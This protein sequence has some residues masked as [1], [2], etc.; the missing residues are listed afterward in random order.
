MLTDGN[1]DIIKWC[2]NGIAVYHPDRLEK[3]VLGRYFNSSKYSSFQ[4]QMNNYNFRKIAGER[5]MSPCSF[6]HD[7]LTTDIGSLLL[8]KKRTL[9]RKIRQENDEESQQQQQQNSE[10][11][12]ISV[13]ES[14]AR[15]VGKRQPTS[16]KEEETTP[17]NK[18]KELSPTMEGPAPQ[19]IA[20]GSTCSQYECYNTAVFGRFYC[21]IHE[22]RHEG[23]THF[24]KENGMCVMHAAELK[25]RSIEAFANLAHKGEVCV[26]HEETVKTCIVVG[27]VNEAHEVL[28][29][30]RHSAHLH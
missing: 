29:C 23:C 1:R 17:N 28:L 18:R 7:N 27:C 3:E 10:N 15:K 14:I 13:E 4:K 2:A 16:T 21:L 30:K 6:V 12:M 19:G 26:R 9:N 5:K 24:V 20:V 25:R 11:V 8:I 22:C